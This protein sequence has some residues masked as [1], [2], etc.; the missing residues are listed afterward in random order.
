MGTPEFARPT[1]AEL[2]RAG[3]KIAA[4]YTQPPRKAG[5][6]M[7]ERRS[8]VHELA[9]QLGLYVRTPAS[10]KDAEEQARFAALELDAAIVVAY[11]LILPP[12]ILASPA[13]GCLN[14]HPSLLPRWRGAA[15]IQRA[16]MAGDAE[17]GI[18]VMRMDEGLDTGPVCL[19]ENIAIGPDM[20]AGELHDELAR[21]GAKLMLRAL[22]LLE[23]GTLD[24][25]PQPDEG[26]TYAAKIDKAEARVDFTQTASA[27]HNQIRGLS[28]FPGAGCE[29]AGDNAL[30]RLKVLRAELAGG[31]SAWA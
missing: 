21:L 11:G 6:G 18:I 4:V 31:T 2:A 13:H 16:I 7:A 5:R 17:T 3:H 14:L 27:V 10:L 1:L 12:A 26:A 15:P 9:D 28:P 24:C 25:R 30:V 23:E 20:T 29:I 22:G 8:V 19:G